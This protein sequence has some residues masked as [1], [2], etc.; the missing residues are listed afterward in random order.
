MLLCQTARPTAS[1]RDRPD[2]RS[3]N[4]TESDHDDFDRYGGA[5]HAGAAGHR[6][7]HRPVRAA[8]GGPARPDG[9]VRRPPVLPC[10]PPDGLRHHRRRAGRRRRGFDPAGFG[11]GRRP[12]AVDGARPGR[13]QPGGGSPAD[14]FRP[15]P[16][17][18]DGRSRAASPMPPSPKPWLRQ[19]SPP[20]PWRPW[21]SAWAPCRACWPWVPGPPRCSVA[22]GNGRRSWP[23]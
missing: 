11:D 12:H 18:A 1:N 16:S 20:A 19:S 13:H 2:I 23:A 14:L 10:R 15:R 21:F 4:L 8:R 6:P 3:G 7:L 5:L 9:K 22:I 17:G